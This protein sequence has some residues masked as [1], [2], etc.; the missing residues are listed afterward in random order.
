VVLSFDTFR[1]ARAQ[2]IHGRD[3]TAQKK[4]ALEN[5]QRFGIGT[6]L[7]NVMIRGL[8]EDEIGD[9][10]Q[11][12]LTH[13]VVRSVTV[14]TMTFTGKGGKN[15]YPRENLPLDAAAKAVETATQ[16]SMRAGDFF[17]HTAAHPLCYSVAY[18]LKDGGD[19]R[20][21]T[22]FFTVDELREM[23][24][25]GYLLQP[26]ER[27]QEMFQRAI[28]RL[29]AEGDAMNLLPAVRRLLE[30]VYPPGKPLTGAERQ[31]A[32]E[33][34][35]LA[36]YLHSHMDE[37]TLDLARLA[38]CPDQVPDPDGR[39][40]PAC[41]YNLFYREKDPRFWLPGGGSSRP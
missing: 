18:Y 9:I 40:I 35:L 1:P 39:L 41:A 24:G 2:K 37:D 30:R 17:A 16:G 23:L 32:A 6:T 5:L 28:D 33:R 29:W 14:Q 19:C 12:A 11:L 13:S 7:L 3:V 8:N 36:V 10:V 22:E 21:L 34:S 4:Q 26:G 27:G 31:A 20:S 15:F 38:V 25:H